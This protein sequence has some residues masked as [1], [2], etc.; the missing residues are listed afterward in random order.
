MIW[1]MMDDV[2]SIV[3]VYA[4][5]LVWCMARAMNGVLKAEEQLE[6]YC[7]VWVQVKVEE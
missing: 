6:V 3:S 4:S 2:W 1:L 5:M 7:I